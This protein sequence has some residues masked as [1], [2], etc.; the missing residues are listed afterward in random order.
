MFDQYSE[1]INSNQEN[2]MEN[3]YKIIDGKDPSQNNQITSD[4]NR[5]LSSDI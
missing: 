4:Q 2:T 5:N 1:A 3:F